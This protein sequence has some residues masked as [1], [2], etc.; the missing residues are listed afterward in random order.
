MK[1]DTVSP[2][3]RVVKKDL[4][5]LK[6][7]IHTSGLLPAKLLEDMMNDYFANPSTEDIW[8]TKE[9]SGVPIMIAYCAPERLTDGT[10]NLYL[11]A[12]HKD[13]QGNGEGAEMM[14]YIEESLRSKGNRI[15]IVETS[16]LPEFERTRK[17]YD[18]CN[19]ERAA[20]IRD[21]YKEGEDKIIFWKKVN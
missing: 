3:R 1:T 16:G 8:L 20:V 10:Y 4:D 17:F 21:F 11:I 14:S 6:T 18:Q 19:Y 13:Y 5:A 9:I 7:V 15:L 12:V 2:I